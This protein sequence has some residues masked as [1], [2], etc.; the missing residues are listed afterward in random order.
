[1]VDAPKP[2]LKWNATTYFQITPFE[3]VSATV[4]LCF[5]ETRFCRAETAA[6]KGPSHSTARQQRQSAHT[7]TPPVALFAR[8]REISVCSNF[9][10]NDYQPLALSSRHRWPAPAWHGRRSPHRLAGGMV[11][12]AP[13]DR[14]SCAVIARILEQSK[15][16]FCGR[17][18]A[19]EIVSLKFNWPFA[20]KRAHTRQPRYFGHFASHEIPASGAVGQCSELAADN[21]LVASSSPPSPRWQLITAWLEVRVLSAPLR[22]RHQTEIFRFFIKSP[23]LAGIRARILSLQAVD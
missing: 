4:G 7:Q 3:R 13:D 17:D 1:V 11:P 10:P 14:P 21:R 23:E 12:T 18:E 15:R 9:Q 16:N 8:R 19:A 20:E 2:L 6:G 22:S 5:R